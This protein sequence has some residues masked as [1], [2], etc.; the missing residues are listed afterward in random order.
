MLSNEWL[1][2][3]PDMTES[4]RLLLVGLEGVEAAGLTFS[5]DGSSPSEIHILS[6]GTKSAKSVARDVQSAIAAAYNVRVDHQIISVATLSQDMRFSNDEARLIYKGIEIKSDAGRIGATVEITCR[7]KRGTG[8]ASALVVPFS[9]RR[10]V[11]NAVLSSIDN[12]F[13]KKNLFELADIDVFEQGGHS[14]AVSQVYS[15]EDDLRLSGSA[16]IR[17]DEDTAIVHSILSAVNRKVSR[18][19]I[20]SK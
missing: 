11:A 3:N 18:L 1:P 6:D 13:G 20:K 16:L 8:T 9:R 4:L 2:N 15:V 7:E 10:C 12:L 19:M 14:V 5:Q 17:S